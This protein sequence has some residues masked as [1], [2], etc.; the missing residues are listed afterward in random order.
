[1]SATI[2]KHQGD[3]D[4]CT[5]NIRALRFIHNYFEAV[6]ADLSLPYPDTK[7]YA[8]STT[9]FDTKN[10]TYH[11][12]STIKT[13]ML[14]LFS[15]FDKVALKAFSIILIDESTE[16]QVFY[17]VTVETMVSF[18]MKG[19]E[20]PISVPRIFVFEIKDTETEDGYDGLQFSKVSLYWDTALLVNEISRRRNIKN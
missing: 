15:P 20:V 16:K 5:K 4:P 2:F 12:A 14:E 6:S 3:F 11:G 17:T 13:W 1:M 10:V 18:F 7:Y 19:D 9:F 8:P